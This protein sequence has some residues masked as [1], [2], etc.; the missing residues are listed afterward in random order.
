MITSVEITVTIEH[1]TDDEY[2]EI[3]DNIEA[4][5]K[6]VN[7]VDSVWVGIGESQ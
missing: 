3:M 5:I 1:Q 7:G 6:S 2:Q 4:D